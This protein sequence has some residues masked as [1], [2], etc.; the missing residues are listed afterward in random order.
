MH[1]W[2]SLTTH[3]FHQR[4]M[5]VVFILSPLW[6]EVLCCFSEWTVCCFLSLSWG[7]GGGPLCSILAGFH[8]GYIT[9]LTVIVVWGKPFS[10]IF[11]K[12][13]IMCFHIAQTKRKR[14]ANSKFSKKQA[15]NW[16]INMYA[17]LWCW[18]WWWWLWKPD[19]RDKKLG[20]I[21]N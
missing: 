2:K 7:R 9:T 4:W 6:L 16:Y 5:M 13:S 17:I 14:V 11:V 8:D 18:C 1:S 21:Q 3:P 15:L 20:Q 12:R 10:S 19:V